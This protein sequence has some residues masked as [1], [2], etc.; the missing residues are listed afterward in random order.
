MKEREEDRSGVEGREKR[1]P[2]LRWYGA[3]RMVNLALHGN[4]LSLNMFGRGL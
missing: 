1:S 2:A 4:S 3:T